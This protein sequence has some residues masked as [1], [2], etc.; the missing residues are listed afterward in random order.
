VLYVR[1]LTFAN[2]KCWFNAEACLETFYILF[3]EAFQF[4]LQYCDSRNNNHAIFAWA[5]SY[6]C[7]SFFN[8]CKAVTQISTDIT[9]M[10]CS[11]CMFL[12]NIFT[13]HCFCSQDSIC[14]SHE[15]TQFIS[16]F[17]LDF[18]SQ[19]QSWSLP[20]CHAVSILHLFQQNKI[21]LFSLE[22]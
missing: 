13:Y 20:F 17:S 22:P 16:M 15:C 2:C 18:L 21:C 8:I 3:C 9:C 14:C 4:Y 12:L 11:E 1:W 6:K 5:H 19:Y 7:M 10:T